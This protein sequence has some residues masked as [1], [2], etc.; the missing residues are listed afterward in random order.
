MVYGLS[1]VEMTQQILKNIRDRPA[2]VNLDMLVVVT[3]PMY[4][5]TPIY[6][7]TPMYMTTPIN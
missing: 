6:M 3:T 1:L 4:M 7:T 2:L 5:T